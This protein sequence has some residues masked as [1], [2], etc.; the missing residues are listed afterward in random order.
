MDRPKRKSL[1]PKSLPGSLDHRVIEFLGTKG[2]LS[3][4][5]AS[6]RWKKI[7]ENF[8]FLVLLRKGK[9]SQIKHLGLQ[10]AKSSAFS[11]VKNDPQLNTL[12]NFRLFF[13]RN[14]LRIPRIK[15]TLELDNC[16]C[17]PPLRSFFPGMEVLRVW[18]L[19]YQTL[20][21]LSD[22]CYLYSRNVLPQDGP[23]DFSV[24]EPYILLENIRT[25]HASQS[26][27]YYIKTDGSLFVRFLGNEAI[28]SNEYKVDLSKALRGF[29]EGCEKF[30][31]FFANDIFFLVQTSRKSLFLVSEFNR[32]TE[33]DFETGDRYQ[34]FKIEFEKEIRSFCVAR[35]YVYIIS[36]DM[37]PYELKLS[38]EELLSKQLN[39][40]GSEKLEWL[41][42][43]P[44][45]MT[46][47]SKQ[48]ISQI[49]Q[50][51][52]MIAFLA[53]TKVKPIEDFSVGETVEFVS[54]S[55]T[56]GA[57]K[58]ILHNKIDGKRLAN[59]E[60]KEAEA[61]FVGGSQ[62][63]E[64][65]R[66]LDEVSLRKILEFRKP[67]IFLMGQNPNRQFGL[68]DQISNFVELEL[69]NFDV[70]EQITHFVIGAYN[71]IITTSKDRCFISVN[72]LEEP[73]S[74]EKQIDK[75]KDKYPE[76]GKKMKP[77]LSQNF[78][79]DELDQ[80]FSQDFKKNGKKKPKST[81][82]KRERKQYKTFKE[83]KAKFVWLDFSSIVAK[84]TPWQD[85]K[86]SMAFHQIRN[87]NNQGFGLLVSTHIAE[88]PLN[89]ETAGEC[90]DYIRRN[91]NF[92]RKELIFSDY[93]SN[94]N[95]SYNEILYEDKRL[96]NVKSIRTL[97]TKKMVWN[98][99]S[100]VFSE[101]DLPLAI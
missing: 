98:G 48:P 29:K 2:I 11:K 5:C 61:L 26:K 12:Q 101:K 16:K 67:K 40:R 53:W 8:L 23:I 85:P 71:S 54:N 27:L 21:K 46:V 75:K 58:V 74:D 30:I 19:A 1:P 44:R 47:F 39:F 94:T 42:L 89:F 4:M 31:E 90:L 92:D 33:T 80:E 59:M 86:Y 95:Y 6:K 63:Q 76:Q 91:K 70:N 3:L 73:D 83:K 17:L 18:A 14:F 32:L 10:P 20:I 22:T 7:V 37:V 93:V 28:C 100:G 68:S 56:K 36:G 41:I 52:S 99:A 35:N 9:L 15:N 25:I 24:L 97:S 49:F 43:R 72:N 62:R 65:F 45:V 60:A 57:E 66:L 88:R 82:Q 96:E 64:L 84:L 87:G 51:G 69:P 34:I 50:N 79:D 13:A 78:D 81:Q 55:R 77:K 38:T